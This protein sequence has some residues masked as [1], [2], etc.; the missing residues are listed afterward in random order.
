MPM[1]SM[2]FV[3]IRLRREAYGQQASKPL[4]RAHPCVKTVV[5]IC[6]IRPALAMVGRYTIKCYSLSQLSDTPGL[7]TESGPLGNRR[8]VCTR[9]HAKA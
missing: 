9:H 2:V 3:R 1:K 8:A 7:V 6:A 5:K 4:Q